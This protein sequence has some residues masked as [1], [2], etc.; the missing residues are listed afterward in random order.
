MIH[1]SSYSSPLLFFL[2]KSSIS[3]PNASASSGRCSTRKSFLLFRISLKLCEVRPACSA[4]NDC[5]KPLLFMISLIFAIIL[6]Y[7]ILSD[8]SL[9]CLI[10]LLI[11][12][13]LLLIDF[14]LPLFY[15]LITRHCHALTN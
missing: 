3:T 15:A 11:F 12:L 7:A 4:T 5:F 13:T 8:E 14:F 9:S 1:N 2:K 6:L 10:L